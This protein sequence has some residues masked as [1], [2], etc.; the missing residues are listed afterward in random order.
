M[1]MK[2]LLLFSYASCLSANLALS[3][4][5]ELYPEEGVFGA[6]EAFVSLKTGYLVDYIWKMDL[7]SK[8]NVNKGSV[9]RLSNLGM[10]GICLSDLVEIDGF[11]GVEKNHLSFHKE[12]RSETYKE[13]SHFSWGLSAEGILNNW[14]KF[15]LGVSSYYQQVPEHT[16]KLL[17]SEHLST[18]D[19]F[20]RYSWGI[21]LGFS[22]DYPPFAPYARIDFQKTKIHLKSL[23]EQAFH[24]KH[25]L[26]LAF[27]FATDPSRGLY[28]DFE[29]RVIQ[30]YALTLFL[31]IRL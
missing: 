15:Q 7:K 12:S 11:I 22:Y 6:H 30:E 16:G 26:G 24:V 1:K 19:R 4:S 28:A 9:S 20:R 14:G 3:P 13:N 17:L 8:L 31:G 27:G 10:I 21:S 18:P 23:P 2:T 25:P 29:F 5:I